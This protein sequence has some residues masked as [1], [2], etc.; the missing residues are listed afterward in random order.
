MDKE[1]AI[2]E[3]TEIE[4][5]SQT[6]EF[7]PAP[8]G[9]YRDIFLSSLVSIVAIFMCVVSSSA[10]SLKIKNSSI[11]VDVS[12]VPKLFLYLAV[13]GIVV[14]IY[15]LVLHKTTKIKIDKLRL[16]HT[17]GIFLREEHNTDLSVISDISTKRNLVD[18]AIN[19]KS[20]KIIAMD[21][22]HPVMNINGLDRDDADMLFSFIRVFAFNRYTEYR[23]FKDMLDESRRIRPTDLQAVGAEEVD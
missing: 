5:F 3:L 9:A 20:I 19:L 18:M 23:K 22:S 4:N 21:E 15:K 6:L 10:T 12:F 13:L 16:V 7:H 17:R 11:S 1:K 14:S 2:S 8:R